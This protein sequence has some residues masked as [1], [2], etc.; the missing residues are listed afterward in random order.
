MP[1]PMST[2][3]IDADRTPN[4]QKP[5]LCFMFPAASRS[6]NSKTWETN[7]DGSGKVAFPRPAPTCVALVRP[8]VFLILFRCTEVVIRTPP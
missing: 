6:A 8:G 2:P 3:S 1:I 7:W 4:A 5:S